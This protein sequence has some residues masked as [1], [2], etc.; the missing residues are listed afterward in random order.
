MMK[1]QER[2]NK[3]VGKKTRQ[4]EKGKAEGGTER[5]KKRQKERRNY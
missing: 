2:R 3:N 4:V 1:L 5:K